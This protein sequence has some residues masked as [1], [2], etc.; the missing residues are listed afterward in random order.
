MRYVARVNHRNSETITH[1]WVRNGLELRHVRCMEAEAWR[2]VRRHGHRSPRLENAQ[3]SKMDNGEWKW[4]MEM[5]G[6]EWKWMGKWISDTGHDSWLVGMFL[7]GIGSSACCPVW[8]SVS[9]LCWWSS[10]L[11]GGAGLLGVN[12]SHLVQAVFSQPL[13]GVKGRSSTSWLSISRM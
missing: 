11:V 10:A 2:G 5:N 1:G 12:F 8:A 4:T 3:R 7:F 9:S 13:F 6:N